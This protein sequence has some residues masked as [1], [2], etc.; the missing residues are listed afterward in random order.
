MDG[1]DGWLVGEIHIHFFQFILSRQ[2]YIL[3]V[4]DPAIL[5]RIDARLKA[6]TYP[7]LAE[8]YLGG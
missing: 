8:Y 1:M 6:K 2:A 5:E 7:A 3:D 4:A